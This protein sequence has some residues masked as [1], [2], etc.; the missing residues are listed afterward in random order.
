MFKKICLLSLFCVLLFQQIV[1]QETEVKVNGEVIAF[2]DAVP[3][4][5]VLIVR[6]KK[7][8]RAKDRFIKVIYGGWHFSNKLPLPAEIHKNGNVWRFKLS[9]QIDCDGVLNPDYSK[10]FENMEKKEAEEWIE[11]SPT[12]KFIRQE[13]AKTFPNEK[14]LRCYSLIS[15]KREAAR[16]AR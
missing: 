16:P 2:L 14:V 10:L 13:D 4:F 5:E 8:K 12:V 7:S 15:L 11:M 6:I 9:R 1:G 3:S